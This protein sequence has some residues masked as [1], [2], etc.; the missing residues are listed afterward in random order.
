MK[1]GYIQRHNLEMNSQLTERFTFKEASFTRRISSRGDRVYCKM[2]C[3]PVDYDEIINNAN[4]MLNNPRLILVEEPFLLN[5][6]LR[7]KTVK[8]VEWAN[9]TDPIEYDLFA[10]IENGGADNA[11]D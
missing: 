3:F 8:W 4:I 9:K 11:A 5:D 10:K 2:L 6:E 7:E 1:L